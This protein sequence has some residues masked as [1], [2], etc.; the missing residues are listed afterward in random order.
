M[1]LTT[2][3]VATA[4]IAL[5]ALLTPVLAQ[6]GLKTTPLGAINFPPGY[7]TVM[8]LAVFAPG[9]CSGRHTHPGIAI[10]PAARFVGGDNSLTV[11]TSGNSFNRVL[12][13]TP[14]ARSLPLLMCS[15]DCTKDVM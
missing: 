4:C 15:I 14:N 12:L 11:G 8:Q 10:E 13:V 7:Q 1:K 5:P 6:E 2:K 9:T 3:F